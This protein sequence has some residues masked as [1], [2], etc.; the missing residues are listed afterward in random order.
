MDEDEWMYEIMSKQV[1]IDYENL[2]KW[3]HEGGVWLLDFVSIY[4]G[5]RDVIDYKV[6]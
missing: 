4:R 5:G 2:G 3:R 6:W 1:D